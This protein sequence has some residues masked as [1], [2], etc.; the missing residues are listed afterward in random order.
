[1]LI[2]NFIKS[3]IILDFKN[4]KNKKSKIKK[5]RNILDDSRN[6]LWI[7]INFFIIFLIIVSISAIIFES[8]WNNNLIYY[9]ELFILDWFISTI[10][11]IE[12]FYRLMMAKNKL[13]HSIKI[14]NIVDL[15][16]FLPFFLQILFEWLINLNLLKALRILRIFRIFKLLRHFK[17][18][19]YI[20]QWLNNFRAEYQIWFIL[21]TII[22]LLSSIFMYNIESSVNP[23]FKSIPDTMRWA[24][25]TTAT[26]W[27]WDVYPITTLWKIIWSIII[28]IWPMFIAM[29]SSITVLVFFEVAHKNK[30][31]KQHN[32]EACPRCNSK[33]NPYDSNY[34]KICWEKLILKNKKIKPLI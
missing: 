22:L 2:S 28:L 31:D 21:V 25:V 26:V 13:K 4:Q 24:I 10:F 23:W 6:K 7:K 8:I 14:M 29:I 16:A 34:C 11:A 30:L 18:I 3:I 33:E 12:Y 5:S 20:L 1:M 19:N 32:K 9:K 27:Y 17:S 15:L